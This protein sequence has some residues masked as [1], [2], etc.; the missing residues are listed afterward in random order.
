MKKLGFGLMRL[1]LNNAA[2]A[3]DIDIKTMERMADAFL[4]RGFT[5]FDT[6]WMYNGFKSEEAMREALIKRHRRDSFTVATKL[7]VMM[8][9]EQG[10]VERIFN[11]Q[12]KKCGVDYFDYY[13]LHNLNTTSLETADRLDCFS[14]IQKMKDAGR[15]RHIGFSFHDHADLLDR[16]LTAHPEAEFVQLQINYLD[17][18]SAGI[19][20]RL[21][22]ETAARH[23]KPV[24]VMEPVK[25]GTLARVPAAAEKIF[26]GCAPDMSPASWAVRFAASLDNAAM[27]LSGMSSFEQMQDNLSYMENFRPL[28][29]KE[30]EVL[31][32]A[33]E[34]IDSSIAIPCTGCRYCVPGCP[35]HIAIPEYFDLYNNKKQMTVE[36]F[37]TQDVYYS[38]YSK[39]HGKASDCISCRKC[40][41]AC[42][43][44]IDIT[45]WLKKVA[46]E[47]EK[48]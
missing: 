44:G 43:Q 5:Y 12:L 14:F 46:A 25:G 24:I 32:K 41:K 10:D 34:I 21:C 39:E 29:A 22:Y 30:R 6:A 48:K 13:L 3:G 18:D 35:K 2:D 17:W 27:V 20:S 47:F 45:G 40:E 9:Q 8:L 26:R 11:E 37:Y 4:E 36:V 19:Q 15:V 1:P 7:P 38:N 33:K 16:I 23:G 42:P 31:A 28:D